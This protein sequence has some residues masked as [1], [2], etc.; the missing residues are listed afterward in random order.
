MQARHE[1]VLFLNLSCPRKV[2]FNKISV[3]IIKNSKSVL[4]RKKLCHIEL[5]ILVDGFS[6]WFFPPQPVRVK[7]GEPWRVEKCQLY[8]GGEW[9][10][11]IIFKESLLNS[12]LPVW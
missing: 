7:R 10:I 1:K 12:V 9:G 5:G 2:R 11:E 8:K 4:L 6:G 3:I